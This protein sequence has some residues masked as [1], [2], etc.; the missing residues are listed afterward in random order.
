M[1][2]VANTDRRSLRFLLSILDSNVSHTSY[3][4]CIELFPKCSFYLRTTLRT[5]NCNVSTGKSNVKQFEFPMSSS[6]FDKLMPR[7]GCS[8]AN[9]ISRFQVGYYFTNDFFGKLFEW[10]LNETVVKIK[11]NQTSSL[12]S[13]CSCSIFMEI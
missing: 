4:F 11:L 3:E 8:K 7:I 1:Q 13:I 5:T 6:C 9:S 12:Y 2:I 10:T